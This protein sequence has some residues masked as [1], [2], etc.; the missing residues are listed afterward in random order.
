MY[1]LYLDDSGSAGNKSEQYFVLGGVAVPENS[2]RWLSHE[3]EKI[4][5]GLEWAGESQDIEFHAADIYGGRKQPWDKMVDRN[6]RIK[7]LKGVLRVLDSANDTI[8]HHN[9]VTCI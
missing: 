3:I 5:I 8:I 4:A 6:A 7:L 1:L 9:C 2:M